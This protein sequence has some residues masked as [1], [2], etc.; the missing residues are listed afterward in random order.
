MSWISLEDLVGAIYHAVLDWRCDGPVNA[1]APQAVT[2]AEFTATLA[3]VLNRP[4][5]LPVPPCVL[6]LALG[7]M[8]EETLL[9]SARVQPS[10]LMEAGYRFRHANLEAAL[11]SLLGRTSSGA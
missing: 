8:A 5:L 4:A 3:R 11:R 7:E 2:N 9:S 1:V 10:K 6:S